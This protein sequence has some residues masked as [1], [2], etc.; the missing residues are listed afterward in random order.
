MRFKIVQ[1]GNFVEA[2]KVMT[3]LIENNARDVSLDETSGPVQAI[4]LM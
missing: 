4:T 1:G 3:G 2:P